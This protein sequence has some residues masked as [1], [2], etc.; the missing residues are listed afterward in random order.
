M[1]RLQESFTDESLSPTNWSISYGLK[2]P[3]ETIHLGRLIIAT[4]HQPLNRIH[5]SNTNHGTLE[6][7]SNTG[8]CS[9]GGAFVFWQRGRNR[10]SQIGAPLC[11]SFAGRTKAHHRPHQQATRS[12]S[13]GRECNMHMISVD[14]MVSPLQKLT[15][16]LCLNKSKRSAAKE[17]H[18]A[19]VRGEAAAY[20]SHYR[21]HA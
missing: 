3:L 16:K 5:I 8:R 15:A 20:F 7:H 9:T 11:I 12:R 4:Y 13:T 18:R 17:P 1:W 19:V 21:T 14:K 2:P 10:P 6:V